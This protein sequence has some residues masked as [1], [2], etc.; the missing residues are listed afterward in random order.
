[1]LRTGTHYVGLGVS[2]IALTTGER[3]VLNVKLEV[4]IIFVPTT[5]CDSPGGNI[6]TTLHLL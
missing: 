6:S 4:Q 5:G 1:L 2:A 3:V